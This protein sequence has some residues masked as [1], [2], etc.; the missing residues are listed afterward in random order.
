MQLEAMIPLLLT[1]SARSATVIRKR[2]ELIES[3]LAWLKSL[4]PQLEHLTNRANDFSV[5]NS[6]SLFRVKSLG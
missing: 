5:K 2:K 4:G 1:S 6:L 3:T